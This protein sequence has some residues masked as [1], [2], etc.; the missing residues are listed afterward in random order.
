MMGPDVAIDPWKANIHQAIKC[1]LTENSLHCRRVK[2]APGESKL[3]ALHKSHRFPFFVPF[4]TAS[5]KI[6][7]VR[8]R[9]QNNISVL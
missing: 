1:Y 8:L 6:L 2:V 7:S 5:S 3:S 4:T 9:Q